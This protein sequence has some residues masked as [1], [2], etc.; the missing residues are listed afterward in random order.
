MVDGIFAEMATRYKKGGFKEKTVFYFAIDEIKKTLT[1]DLESCTIENGKTVDN[2]DCFCKTS[3]EFFL[4][5]VQNGYQ[6][7]MKDF[8]SGQIKS[9]APFLLQ[10][11]LGAFTKEE[12]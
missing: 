10:Q 6:P 4:K 2:A 1:F 11:F 7:G 8:M 3:Q 12:A 9:N 5:I